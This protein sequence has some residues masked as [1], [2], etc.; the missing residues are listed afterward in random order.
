MVRYDYGP[1]IDFA[2]T[3]DQDFLWRIVYDNS[4]DQLQFARNTAAS[5]GFNGDSNIYCSNYGWVWDAI[6]NAQNTA[7]D[8]E[9]RINALNIPGGFQPTALGGVG[10]YVLVEQGATGMPGQ[11]VGGITVQGV[12]LGGTWMA[13]GGGQTDNNNWYLWVRVA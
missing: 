8:A 13:M 7:N 12:G 5:V 11:Q 6:H 1:Y 3:A 2:R 4:S 10:S 9:N